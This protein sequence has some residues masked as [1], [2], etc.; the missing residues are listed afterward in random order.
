MV[1]LGPGWEGLDFIA[2]E[3]ILEEDVLSVLTPG[4]DQT[5]CISQ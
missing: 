5:G 1:N 4:W 2:F 3:M